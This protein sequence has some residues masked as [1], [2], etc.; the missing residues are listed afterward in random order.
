M[1][2]ARS[3]RFLGVF[4]G[5]DVVQHPVQDIFL[6]PATRRCEAGGIAYPD[7]LTRPGGQPVLRAERFMMFPRMTF[8]VQDMLA[9]VGMQRGQ[10]TGPVSRP[11]V[12]AHPEE[13]LDL[14]AHIGPG[15]LRR[16]P[17]NV[18]DGR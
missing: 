6:R 13:G 18:A 4:A 15:P 12:G 3:Q 16:E 10:P 17:G 7:F 11:F 2:L 9:V 5:G 14:R 1:I 8:L